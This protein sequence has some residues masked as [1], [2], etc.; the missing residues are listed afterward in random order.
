MCESVRQKLGHTKHLRVDNDTVAKRQIHVAFE[1]PLLFQV[2][3]ANIFLSCS[4]KGLKLHK[5]GDLS[6]GGMT[7]LSPKMSMNGQ[8]ASFKW[9]LNLLF[10]EK[11]C[12]SITVWMK[13]TRHDQV[14]PRAL[15]QLLGKVWRISLFMDVSIETS[16]HYSIKLFICVLYSSFCRYHNIRVLSEPY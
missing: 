10:T 11:H 9:N 6:F 3:L 2:Q 5:F 12:S 4:S 1:F 15:K 16:M 8:G 13:G 14:E 7:S